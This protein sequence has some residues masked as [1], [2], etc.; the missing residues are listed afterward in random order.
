MRKEDTLKGQESKIPFAGTVNHKN[1]LGA[2]K[3]KCIKNHER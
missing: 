1:M 2:T 3:C